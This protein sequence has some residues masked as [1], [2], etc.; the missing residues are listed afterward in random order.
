MRK[1]KGAHICLNSPN[2][3]KILRSGNFLQS[4]KAESLSLAS[5]TKPYGTAE[6]IWRIILV[7]NPVCD[8]CSIVCVVE[9]GSFTWNKQDGGWADKRPLVFVL[10]QTLIF[11]EK[12][13][14]QTDP[15]YGLNAIMVTLGVI[16]S[17]DNFKRVKFCFNL[18]C[19]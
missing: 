19:F 11:S 6:L 13:Y 4:R 14:H 7:K 17:A 12:M 18:L 1:T 10:Q 16:C 3:S 15:V 5:S 9:I 8:C 2:N